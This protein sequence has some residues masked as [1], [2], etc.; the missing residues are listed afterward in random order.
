LPSPDRA[1]DDVGERKREQ[2]REASKKPN[3]Q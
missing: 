2:P 1:A 3:T